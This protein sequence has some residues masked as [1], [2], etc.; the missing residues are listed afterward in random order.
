[1]AGW[2]RQGGARLRRGDAAVVTC[3]DQ[4]ARGRC[5]GDRAMA[6][7]PRACLAECGRTRGR[8]GVSSRLIVMAD[9]QGIRGGRGEG[10]REGGRERERERER[11]RGSERA[12]ERA[13]E[14]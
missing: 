7:V 4:G 1:M 11:E 5:S 2:L 13:R 14:S 9:T 12:R 3:L 10:G 8:G 6:A